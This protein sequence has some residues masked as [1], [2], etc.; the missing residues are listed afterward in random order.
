MFRFSFGYLIALVF[1]NEYVLS[2]AKTKPVQNG[3]IVSI[4]LKALIGT[5]AV[6]V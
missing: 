2:Q 3:A 5:K 4:A 1:I 6:I